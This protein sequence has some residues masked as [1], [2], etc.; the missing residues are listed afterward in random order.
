MNI[1]SYHKEEMKLDADKGNTNWKDADLL[2][3]KQI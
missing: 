3:L 2:E 1:S